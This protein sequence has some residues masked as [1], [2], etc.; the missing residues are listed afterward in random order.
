LEITLPLDNSAPAETTVRPIASTALDVA[1][2]P[3]SESW[4]SFVEVHLH[5]GRF[6][7]ARKHL[8]R[9]THPIIGDRKHGDN[10]HNH[11]FEKR[12]GTRMIFLRAAELRFENPSRSTRV[13]ARVGIP[14]LWE[15]I[16]TDLGLNV[17]DEFRRAPEVTL[18]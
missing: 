12:Y 10:K 4:Y 3:Y 14:E 8:R 18:G 17:P 6:H 15:P 1:V 2:G 7:Q 16:L 11:F 13:F 9:A 5:T